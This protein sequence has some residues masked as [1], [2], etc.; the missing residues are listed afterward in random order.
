MH[1]LINFLLSFHNL[2]QGANIIHEQHPHS[3]PKMYFH[4]YYFNC[5][6]CCVTSYISSV[7]CK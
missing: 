4:Y 3:K 1:L 7:I 6:I 2:F 5:F